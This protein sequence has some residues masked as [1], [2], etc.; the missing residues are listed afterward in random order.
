[1]QKLKISSLFLF[2]VLFFTT[3]KPLK[4][5]NNRIADNSS[6]GWFAFFGNFKLDERWSVH[7]EFQ[8]RRT[9]FLL[10]PQ[11]NIFRT[12]LNYSFHDQVTGRFG[13]LFADTYPYG[14]IPIQGAGKL[15]PEHRIYQM[16]TIN[17][18]V[19][20]VNLTHRFMLEQRWVG[21]FESASSGS[22]DDYTYLNRTRYM[23][24]M[25]VPFKGIPNQV[26]AAY[27]AFYDEVM[28]GFGKNVNQ[29][30]FDQN[31]IGLLLGYKFNPLLRI[32][33]GFLNQT[34]QLGR[35]VNQRN[36]FQYN[37]GFI[38]NTYITL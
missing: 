2:A 13:Y 35:L 34:A 21:T 10:E 18:P 28:V 3:S 20:R 19:G 37:S 1:M 22:V 32:E 30:V 27:F 17:N 25:D 5:Q 29:N 26:K 12:G 9:E 14:E 4:A 16:M 15:F 24:R 8:W 11:Q 38:V 31:R 33:G 23:I 36:V 7:A 6:I